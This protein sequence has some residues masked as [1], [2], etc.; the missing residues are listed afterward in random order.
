MVQ[1]VHF[2][3]FPDFSPCPIFKMLVSCPFSISHIYFIWSCSY[4]IM[5]EKVN[6]S[7]NSSQQPQE[8]PF[9]P[10][11]SSCTWT[12]KLFLFCVHH[13]PTIQCFQVSIVNAFY[14]NVLQYFTL[15]W[16]KCHSFRALLYL[17][18]IKLL[19]TYQRIMN[20]PQMNE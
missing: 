15:Y 5:T 19:L 3:F 6:V 10:Q 14:L 11:N 17:K 1:E 20:R 2:V 18:A 7:S 13:R 16:E 9:S 8:S 12:N 4:R